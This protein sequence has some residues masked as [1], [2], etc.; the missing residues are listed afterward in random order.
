[1]TS[2]KIDGKTARYKGQMDQSGKAYG[3]GMAEMVDKNSCTWTWTGT[4][5]QNK[6]EGVGKEM[7]I[8]HK[9]LP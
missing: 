2:F 8:I 3:Y 4:F 9:Y 5:L 6:L 1:M 7:K